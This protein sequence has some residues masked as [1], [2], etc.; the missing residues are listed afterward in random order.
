ME[1]RYVHFARV[2]EEREESSH[3]KK[4]SPLK[5]NSRDSAYFLLIFTP[6]A[7]SPVNL[8]C[9]FSRNACMPSVW[10]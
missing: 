7:Y 10:S 8:A 4:Q 3:N 9:R 2:I 5:I 6:V 1:E